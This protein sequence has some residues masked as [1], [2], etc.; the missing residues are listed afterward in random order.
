MGLQR[1]DQEDRL[2]D[3]LVFDCGGIGLV[4]ECWSMRLMLWS[5]ISIVAR[6]YCDD[7]LHM[8]CRQMS[9]L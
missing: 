4:L 9:L 8:I 3:S 2:G 1:E 7:H 6:P 5:R